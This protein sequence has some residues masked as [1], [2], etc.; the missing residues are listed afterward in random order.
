MFAST[1]S[2]VGRWLIALDAHTVRDG[3]DTV[4]D[5]VRRADHV[6]AEL[7][8]LSARLHDVPDQDLTDLL[9]DALAR[10]SEALDRLLDIRRR[11]DS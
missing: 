3:Q 7:D 10:T 9:H 2:E 11:L 8:R 4:S 1:G 6:V 5:L